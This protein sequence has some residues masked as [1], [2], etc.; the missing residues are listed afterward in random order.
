MFKF[1]ET[2]V[3]GIRHLMKPTA[4]FTLSRIDVKL[5][6]WPGI[7][8]C[9]S[10]EADHELFCLADSDR[11]TKNLSFPKA[12]SVFCCIKSNLIFPAGLNRRFFGRLGFRN[13]FLN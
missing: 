12:G 2:I 5:R 11:P 3:P 8:L 6:H 13:I 10:E 4:G 7:K 1:F 9:H